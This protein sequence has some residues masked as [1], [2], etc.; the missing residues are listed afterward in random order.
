MWTPGFR[1]HVHTYVIPL[2]AVPT[3]QDAFLLR[4]FNQGNT[5]PAGALFKPTICASYSKTHVAWL[6]EAIS[7]QVLRC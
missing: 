1:T 7:D 3:T 6:S 5:I 4:V 2:P